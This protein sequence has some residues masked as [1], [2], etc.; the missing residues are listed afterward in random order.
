MQL[1]SRLGSSMLKSG[2]LPQS[3]SSG[4]SEPPCPSHEGSADSKRKTPDVPTDASGPD[5][6]K[7]LRQKLTSRKQS[8]LHVQK[9]ITAQQIDAVADRV[10]K[11]V[12]EWRKM[13]K[14]AFCQTS[15]QEAIVAG[16]S[17]VLPSEG[18]S[19]L[20]PDSADTVRASTFTHLNTLLP[21]VIQI[22]ARLPPRG[23][24]PP[25]K[26]NSVSVVEGPEAM[27]EPSVGGGPEA[28]LEPPVVGC[29]EAMPEPSVVGGLE[30]KPEVAVAEGAEAKPDPS[31][32]ENPLAAFGLCA[33]SSTTVATVAG[34]IAGALGFPLGSAE[35]CVCVPE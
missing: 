10:Q 23:L 18:P 31:V 8:M 32:T 3:A 26:V 24:A 4:Q 14:A 27:P 11:Q 25:V 6:K 1:G 5:K 17:R 9:V 29:P 30:A 22:S 15:S 34:G 19:N 28:T 20:E 13:R 33:T 16:E 7:S 21:E 12:E 2:M 35:D